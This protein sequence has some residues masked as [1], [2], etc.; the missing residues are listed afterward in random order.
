MINFLNVE[1]MRIRLDFSLIIILV[2]LEWYLITVFIPSHFSYLS[3][4][5][6]LAIV[7]AINIILVVSLMVHESAHVIVA[8]IVGIRIRQIVVF[9]FGGVYEFESP[10]LDSNA[11]NKFC[12]K[13]FALAGPAGSALLALLFALT[14]LLEFQQI[15]QKELFLVKQAMSIILIYA[16][17]GNGLLALVNI[18]P[19]LSLDGGEI[20]NSIYLKRKELSVRTKLMVSKSIS[21]S[22]LLAGSFAIFLFSFYS[23]LLLILFAWALMAG[24]Q[25]YVSSNSI[26]EPHTS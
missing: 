17:V 19:V 25:K 23:G 6:Q 18:L 11:G 1:H 16:S 9:I 8:S 14:W 26:L 20:L 7:V 3:F 22:F 10:T 13:K 15:E 5:N 24:L 21:Y 12:S 2:I 4:I